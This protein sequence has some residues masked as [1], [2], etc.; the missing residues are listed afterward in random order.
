[1]A[2][3]CVIAYGKF[4]LSGISGELDYFID[5]QKKNRR[6]TSN[7]VT[8]EWFYKDKEGVYCH[9]CCDGWVAV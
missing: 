4:Q 6:L 3:R 7:G 2:G 5:F 9:R 1:M 8:L